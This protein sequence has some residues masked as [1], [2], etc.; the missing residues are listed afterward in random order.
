M[1]TTADYFAAAAMAS[2]TMVAALNP[3]LS[4]RTSRPAPS[5]PPSSNGADDSE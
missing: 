1:A 2:R 4:A 3:Q 5:S